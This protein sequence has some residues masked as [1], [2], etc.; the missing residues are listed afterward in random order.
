MDDAQRQA[1]ASVRV[2]ALTA[3]YAAAMQRDS[4]VQAGVVAVY[5]IV[6][7]FSGVLITSITNHPETFR[8][9]LVALVPLPVWVLVTLAV[10]MS[11][12]AAV[13]QRRLEYFQYQLD[14]IARIDGRAL[15]AFDTR[16]R[17]GLGGAVG[18]VLL[19]PAVLLPAM[20]IYCLIRASSAGWGWLGW[21]VLYAIFSVVL[22]AA[23][24]A[25]R[26]LPPDSPQQFP[27]APGAKPAQKRRR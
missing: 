16:W 14:A 17:W 27:A 20:T 7:A 3:L 11:K 24:M 9:S 26:A 15:G 22:F 19:I 13:N 8:G 5:T 2:S 18:L 25:G 1:D 4:A 23:A 21:A 12:A 10:I 6:F